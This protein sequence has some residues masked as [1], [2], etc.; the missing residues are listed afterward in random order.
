MVEPLKNVCL[1]FENLA[2]SIQE[3]QIPWE[4]QHAYD[5][6]VLGMI[7]TKAFSK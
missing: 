4:I 1:G 5:I 2:R 7:E 3:K 6:V